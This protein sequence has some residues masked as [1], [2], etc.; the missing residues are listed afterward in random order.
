[1]NPERMLKREHFLEGYSLIIETLHCV[2]LRVGV[3]LLETNVLPF[4]IPDYFRNI[5]IGP[6]TLS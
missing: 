3:E 6:L 1:M 2:L 5:L 4:G